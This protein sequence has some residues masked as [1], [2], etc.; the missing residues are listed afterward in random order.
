MK[1]SVEARL[2]TFCSGCGI[3]Y[4]LSLIMEPQA[5]E[6]ERIALDLFKNALTQV[7]R[8]IPACENCKKITKPVDVWGNYEPTNFRN[9]SRLGSRKNV[10]K[11]KRA[12]GSR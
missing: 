2:K 8:A 11:R 7:E 12:K 1:V 4:N 10:R 6:S 3:Q 5:L 9:N